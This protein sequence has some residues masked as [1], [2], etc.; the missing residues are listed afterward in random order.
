MFWAGECHLARHLTMLMALCIYGGNALKDA[1]CSPRPDWSKGVRLVGTNEGDETSDADQEY[2]LASTHT[3]NT[4]VLFSYLLH[5]HN[6]YGAGEGRWLITNLTGQ[7]SNSLYFQLWTAALVLWCSFI[8]WGRLYLGMHSPIDIVG[9]VV[10]AVMLLFIYIPIEDFMDAWM[11]EAMWTPVY[12]SFFAVLLCWTYPK[13]LRPTPS[14]NYAVYFTGTAWGLIIGIWR[15]A[16]F[17][18][19]EASQAIRERR[20]PI[21][22]LSCVTFVALRFVVGLMVVL[23][24]RAVAKEIAKVVVPLAMNLCKLKHS[25]HDKFYLELAEKE[26]GKLHFHKKEVWPEPEGYNIL[27]GIRLL[28]YAAVG[29][30]VV[31]PAYQSFVWLGI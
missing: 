27:T 24:L 15:R 28:T 13:P 25:D 3:I 9:G 30:A 8:M 12:Q 5:Y 6:I 2:G 20:G 31:E 18:S 19:A 4:I 7:Y 10:V 26:G 22:S 29:W 16:D 23:V 1:L 11:R 14:F 17:H 21:F